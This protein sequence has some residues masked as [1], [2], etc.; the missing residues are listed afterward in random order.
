MQGGKC[1][2]LLCKACCKSKCYRDDLDCTG[3]RIWVKTS[4]IKATTLPPKEVTPGT[5]S[6]KPESVHG[7]N[8]P[9]LT[10]LNN[11]AEAFSESKSVNSSEENLHCE[12]NNAGNSE[13]QPAVG[14]ENIVNG[15]KLTGLWINYAKKCVVLLLN[16][17]SCSFLFLVSRAQANEKAT[18]FKSL[19]F[20]SN[21][22][23]SSKLDV[24]L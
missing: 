6:P 12:I 1:E 10:N 20:W 2:Y 7:F 22:Y 3:H 21:E 15:D 16:I 14:S 5:V 11:I 9:C 19:L 13:S 17:F 23:A 8:S 24:R 4:R 18:L